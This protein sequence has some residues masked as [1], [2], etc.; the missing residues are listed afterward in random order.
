MSNNERDPSSERQWHDLDDTL[1]DGPSPASIPDEARPWLAEQRIM[2]GLLRALN[3][4]D[5]TAREARIESVM[6]RMEAQTAQA[7]RRHWLLVSVAAMLLATF[8]VWFVLPPALPTAEAAMARAVDELARNVDRKFHVKLSTAGRLRPEK[9]FHEFDLTVQPGMRFLIDGRFAFAGFKAAE[10]RIGC[11]GETVWVETKNGR[12]RRS[13]L[14]ADRE[15]LL[16]GLGDILDIAYLDLHAFT[17]KLP[18]EFDM[19]LVG[20]SDGPSGNRQLHIKARRR[21]GRGAF[22]LRQAELIVDELTGMVTHFDAQ[23]RLPTGGMRHVLIDYL[24]VPSEGIVKYS[25]PW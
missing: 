23:L 25:R 9:V 20:H 18:G 22:R 19:H 21:A 4:A 17:E 10:G 2:H 6:Q 8:A 16:A 15:Q 1:A 5:A 13:G 24:G 11:D 7:H 3:T 14:L 12:F